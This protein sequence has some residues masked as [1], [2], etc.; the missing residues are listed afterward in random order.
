MADIPPVWR[1]F[2]IITLMITLLYYVFYA[3]LP[4]DAAGAWRLTSVMDSPVCADGVDKGDACVVDGDCAASTCS[5]NL[6]FLWLS[7]WDRL[8]SLMIVVPPLVILWALHSQSRGNAVDQIIMPVASYVILIYGIIHSLINVWISINFIGGLI[9]CGFIFTVGDL[10]N[11]KWC[12]PVTV[13]AVG[14][15]IVFIVLTIM[16]FIMCVVW[17]IPAIRT[18]RNAY[19][20]FQARGSTKL[21]M[22]MMNGEARP[23][24]G[25]SRGRTGVQTRSGGM[26]YI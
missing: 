7:Y 26:K 20:R 10:P 15:A 22:P 18:A 21:E 1:V 13:Q 17:A 12:T 25:A 3:A 2:I 5:D 23:V 11:P 6:R 8:L 19:R 9:E 14:A 24:T 16:V 4:M